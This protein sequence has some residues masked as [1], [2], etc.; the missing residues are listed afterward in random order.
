MRLIHGKC[1]RAAHKKCNFMRSISSY[2]LMHSRAASPMS[3]E[4]IISSALTRPDEDRCALVLMGGGARTAYQVGVLQAIGNMLQRAPGQS[5]ATF[6]F[7]IL[8]GTS[9]GALN[10]TFLASRAQDGLEA[11]THLAKF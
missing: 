7:R 9:A 6:P 1:N 3:L 10:A 4:T 5:A 8:V 2:Y 11:V